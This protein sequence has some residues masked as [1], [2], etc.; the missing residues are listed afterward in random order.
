MAK[1]QAKHLT[2][3]QRKERK[4]REKW[5][6]KHGWSGLQERP[7]IYGGGLPSLGKRG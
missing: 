3:A 1:K 7:T 4:R 5:K 2:K 6:K